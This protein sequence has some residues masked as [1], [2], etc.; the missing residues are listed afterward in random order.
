MTLSTNAPDFFEAAEF[1]AALEEKILPAYISK[2]RWFGGKARS[3]KTFRVA[4][5]LRL[6]GWDPNYRLGLVRITFADGSDDLY[7]LPLVTLDAEM[8]GPTVEESPP[9]LVAMLDDRV[10]LLDALYHAPY[11]DALVAAM[12]ADV[13]DGPLQAAAG[14]ALPGLLGN[15]QLPLASRVLKVEQSNSSMIYG[16][17]LFVKIFRKLEAGINPDAEILRFLT[18]QRNFANAPAFGGTLEFS[19]PGESARLLALA[20]GIVPNVGD[21]WSFVLGELA[22]FYSRV[23]QEGRELSDENLRDLAGTEF[24]RRARQLG[25]RTGEM[26]V[27]LAGDNG[28]PSFAPEPFTKA[29]QEELAGNVE[30]ALGGVLRLLREREPELGPGVRDEVRTLLEAEPALVARAREI[31]AAPISASKTRHHGDYHLGQVLNSGRDFVIIDYEGEPL[32][33]LA[34]RRRKRSPLR[35]VAGMLRSF[36][37][38]AHSALNTA[39]G[40]RESL[41]LWAE[42]WTSLTSAT[43]LEG[44]REAT[45]G[46]PFVPEPPENFDRLLTGFL[47]E[48]AAYEVN[49][50]LNNRPDWLV[51]PVRGL[52]GLVKNPT[53]G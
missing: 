8:A 33:S 50:E 29:D 38:A 45:A 13:R 7:Q 28:D 46:A 4:E 43:F 14:S 16:D 21:A 6:P 52:A 47:L 31:A 49:Y 27:A 39:E 15:Q 35:D 12:V 36:H 1:R 11:R 41:T 2:C 30:R 17:G 25:Q 5:L 37:Y 18:E 26:H 32:R 42:A 24:L 9:A 48:K 44:W 19:A 20:I 34:E 40:S 3:P 10:A 51:I 23:Q 53:P 22:D